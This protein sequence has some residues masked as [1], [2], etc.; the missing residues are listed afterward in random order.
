MRGACQLAFGAQSRN[1]SISLTHDSIPDREGL[2]A[3]QR[4]SQRQNCPTFGVVVA[5]E[6]IGTMVIGLVPIL[7][8]PNFIMCP[9]CLCQTLGF[10]RVQLFF[11]PVYAEN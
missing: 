10:R 6:D 2:V 7:L 8:C 3:A 5:E 1:V 4:C 9:L 11:H